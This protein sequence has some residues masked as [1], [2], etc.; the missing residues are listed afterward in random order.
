MY[1][2]N[3]SKI[4]SQILWK[5]NAIKIGDFKL[6]SGKRSRIYIDMRAILGYPRD[7]S[8]IINSLASITG[9]IGRQFDIECIVGIATGGLVWSAPIALFLSLP[10]AYHRGKKKEHGLV[11]VI[12]GCNVRGKN[13][14]IIDDVATTGSSIILAFNDIKTYGGNVIAAL[15]LVDRCQGAYESLMNEGLTLYNLTNLY[16]II[17]TGVELKFIS[18]RVADELLKEVHCRSWNGKVET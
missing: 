16:D 14:L 11:N 15:V 10:F 2:N 18:K 3:I 13:V 6:S 12:E 17:E 9:S 5:D 1:M 8:W 4:I 7:F